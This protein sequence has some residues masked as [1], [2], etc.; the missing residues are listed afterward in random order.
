M[1]W[2]ESIL[3]EVELDGMVCYNK[4]ALPCPQAALSFSTFFSYKAGSGPGTRLGVAQ[5][6][7]WE[8]PRDKD[9]SGPGTRLGVAQGQG[10][11]WPRGKA[12]SGPGTRLRCT[13]S[14][15]KELC[16]YSNF[17]HVK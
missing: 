5:G 16:K 7:D 13:Y 4:E 17:E 12:G 10:W 1:P 6:Q 11:E 2:C 14:L 8:W 3:T 15:A 9:G